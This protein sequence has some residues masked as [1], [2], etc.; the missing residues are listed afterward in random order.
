MQRSRRIAAIVSFI[1]LLF[2]LTG[3]EVNDNVH[4]PVIENEASSSNIDVN[5]LN[6]EN[7]KNI[8]KELSSEKYNG[9]LAGTEGNELAT[10][11]I[12]EYFE[13]IGLKN[14][15]GLE[16]YRQEYKQNVRFTN[17]PPI[18]GIM[19]EKGEF[20]KEFG[21]L[22]NFS[23]QTFITALS[24]NGEVRGE[25]VLIEKPEQLTGDTEL[26]KDKILLI[27]ETVYKEMG[28]RHLVTC[29]LTAGV[30][31]KGIIYEDD[32]SNPNHRYNTFIVGPNAPYVGTFDKEAPMMFMSDVDTFK[33]MKEVAEKGL[34]IYMKSD[35]SIENV[36][37]SNVIGLVEGSDEELRDEFVIIGAHFDH[38]GDNKNGTYNPGAFDNGTGTATMMEV[39]RVLQENKI[40]PKKSILFIAFNGEEEGLYGSHYYADYPVYPLNDRTV[41]INLD[42]VGTKTSMPVSIWSYD[43]TN[44]EF[45]N[46]MYKYAKELNIK[47][48]LGAG[49]GSDHAPFAAKGVDAICFIDQDFKNGYHTPN[50]TIDTVDEK[51]LQRL[52]NSYLLT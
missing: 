20:Q 36:T 51:N 30:N 40:K 15:K 8:I 24:I 39:A 12:V 22:E 38:V 43:E 46:S 7:I 6:S 32:I 28:S 33:E 44:T 1:M 31:I 29:I 13:K 42:M 25:A 52:L 37:A 27:T 2:I 21:Y 35:Y 41:M 50:D 5:I 48:E 18:L 47:S 17:S 3:C 4:T 19:D 14:P 45:R 26:L 49:Q 9:R 10:E 34:E 11:Y 16:N 23:V